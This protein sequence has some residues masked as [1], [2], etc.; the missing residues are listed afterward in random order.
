M[1]QRTNIDKG[2]GQPHMISKPRTSPHGNAPCDCWIC[3]ASTTATIPMH[4]IALNAILDKVS[5]LTKRDNA[6]VI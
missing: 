5:L 2:K 4:Q 3:S 6:M 1:S